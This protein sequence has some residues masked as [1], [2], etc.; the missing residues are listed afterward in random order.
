MGD[1]VPIARLARQ[2]IRLRGK[3]PERDIPVQFV[4]LRPGEKLHE[5]LTHGFETLS[6]SSTGGVNTVSG[7]IAALEEVMPAIATLIDCASERDELGARSELDAVLS[8]GQ[9]ERIESFRA[10]LS[11]GE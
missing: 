1:P 6:P 9:P 10:R 2:L 5:A 4:G 11:A 3:E 7:P 8:L